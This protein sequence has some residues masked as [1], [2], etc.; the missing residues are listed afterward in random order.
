[1][2]DFCHLVFYDES[3]RGCYHGKEGVG[4]LTSAPTELLG[5]TL[6]ALRKCQREETA[7][8]IKNRN[9]TQSG[10]NKKRQVWA[11]QPNLGIELQAQLGWSS[12]EIS[13]QESGPLS[14]SSALLCVD[15][16]P[17]QALPPA[18]HPHNV[19]W[20]FQIMSL[21]YTSFEKKYRL[22]FHEFPKSFDLNFIGLI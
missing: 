12:R 11:H 9:S 13:H 16:T 10:L 6:F 18:P 1:M 5:T 8:V 3:S 7:L 17:G 4:H 14:F 2:S 20:Q 21:L 19:P 22:S 15:F